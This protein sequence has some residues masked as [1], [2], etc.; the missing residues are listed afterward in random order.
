MTPV[1]RVVSDRAAP[2]A[3]ASAPARIRCG[4][5]DLE[6]WQASTK[7]LRCAGPILVPSPYPS[8]SPEAKVSQ[9]RCRTEQVPTI[10]GDVQEHR[11]LTVRLRARRP[12]ELDAGRC[13]PTLRRSSYNSGS[14]RTRA[15]D[16][17]SGSLRA[18]L[19]PED[20]RVREAGAGAY[21]RARRKRGRPRLAR[22]S[23]RGLR[24]VGCARGLATTAKSATRATPAPA[25]RTRESASVHQTRSRADIRFIDIFHDSISV[26][27]RTSR[28]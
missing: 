19:Q 7:H 8:P 25:S 3:R 17:C 27:R 28:T 18:R 11:D 4:W 16:L 21:A 1:T 6:A 12:H 24:R 13:C 14:R 26:F 10:A 2:P 22:A 23:E 9:L 20:S 5:S 15:R